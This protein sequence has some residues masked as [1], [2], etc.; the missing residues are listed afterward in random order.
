MRN[1]GTLRFADGTHGTDTGTDVYGEVLS[2]AW[3]RMMISAPV[4]ADAAYHFTAAGMPRA[5][6]V[7]DTGWTSV[8]G[9]GP[10]RTAAPSAGA[11]HPYEC[12]ALA[13]EADGLA[14]F[15]VDPVRRTCRRLDAGPFAGND[16]RTAGLVAPEAGEALIILV[17]RP[18]LSMRKYGDRGYL[19]AQLDAAHLA[20]NL[21]GVAR[22]RCG[23]A[24]LRLRIA[25]SSM[26]DLL[27]VDNP[28]RHVHSVLTVGAGGDGTV[29]AGWTVTDLRTHAPRAAEDTSWLEQT[30]WDSLRPLLTDGAPPVMRTA[31]HPLTGTTDLAAGDAFPA[32]AK[33]SGLSGARRSSKEFPAVP[34]SADALRRALSAMAVPLTT[35]LPGDTAIEVTLVARTVT[36]TAPGSYPLTGGPH[37]PLDLDGDQVVRACMNQEHLRHAAAFVVFHAPRSAVTERRPFHMRELLFRAGALSQLVYLGATEAGIGVTA[38]GGFDA[39]RWQQLAGLPADHE[40]LYMVLLGGASDDGVKWDR[41]QAA[42]A[43]NES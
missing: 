24:H 7:V 37:R 22:E 21:L 14:L 16:L 19:Y 2:R 20:T 38:I 23:A 6:G 31:E 4:V 32:R 1:G 9:A 11:I 39:R 26:L 42:Y 29:P 43:H 13:V 12:Y 28:G 34:L 8:S 25:R 17:S 5:L 27:A 10:R 36:G 33:W 3:D 30:C 41:L 18:W 40:V 35:D 15:H